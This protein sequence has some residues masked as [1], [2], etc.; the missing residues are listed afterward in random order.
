MEM[1][2]VA[3]RLSK[4]MLQPNAVQLAIWFHDAVYDP[5]RT[6]NEERSADLAEE[7]LTPFPATASLL[8]T[9]RE[10]ILATRHNSQ[11]MDADAKVILDA[12]LAILGSGVAR[13]M[14]Y[15]AA[16]RQ[17]YAHIPDDAFR[18]GRVKIIDQFLSRERIYSTDVLFHEA[19]STARANLLAER[20]T[21]LGDC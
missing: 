11:L 14:Q 21:Y 7:L 3:G 1:L 8:P 13:Y 17:E 4:L 18:V 16:I 19:E 9:I 2:K 6:D 12:D 10:L 20:L 15:S 5:K